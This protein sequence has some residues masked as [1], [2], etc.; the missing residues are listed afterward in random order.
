MRGPFFCAA[1]W[2][3]IAV[4]NTCGYRILEGAYGEVLHAAAQACFPSESRDIFK[5]NPE[6]EIVMTTVQ[7]D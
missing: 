4:F 1:F 2:L 5:Q 3:C 7:L 6:V